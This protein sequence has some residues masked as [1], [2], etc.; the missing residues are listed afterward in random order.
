MPEFRGP[1]KYVKKHK[2]LKNIKN[3]GIESAV[4]VFHYITY[5]IHESRFTVTVNENTDTV[6]L[7]YNYNFFDQPFDEIQPQYGGRF[8]DLE[9]PAQELRSIPNTNVFEYVLDGN[10]M[11][12]GDYTIRGPATFQITFT[13]AAADKLRSL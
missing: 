11:H 5:E 13:K 6:N 4:F 7:Y 12:D 3:P 9:F 8:Y 2:I 1:Q 10:E